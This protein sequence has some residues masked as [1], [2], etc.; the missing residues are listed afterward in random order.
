[1][2]LLGNPKTPSFGFR[3]LL[4][5]SFFHFFCRMTQ[6][7]QNFSFPLHFPSYSTRRIFLSSC[8]C[9]EDKIAK[10]YGDIQTKYNKF[11]QYQVKIWFILS[12]KTFPRHDTAE[13]ED[14]LGLTEG[15]LRW[16]GHRRA[17]VPP[18]GPRLAQ[19][20]Q[21]EMCDDVTLQLWVR[22]YCYIVLSKL[23]IFV[24]TPRNFF[25]LFKHRNMKLQDP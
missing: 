23:F 18:E 11:P 20:T 15:S 1:M 19:E 6:S 9:Y 4:R 14:G 12:V 21:G 3:M 17:S 16:S 10:R 2:Q 8:F 25:S 24:A 22:T 13:P 7:F 5:Y